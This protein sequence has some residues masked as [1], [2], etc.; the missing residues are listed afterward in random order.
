MIAHLQDGRYRWVKYPRST[1]DKLLTFVPGP[2]NVSIESNDD[3]SLS[4]SFFGTSAE[5]RFVPVEP[6]VFKQI[7]GGL[8]SIGGLQ[9]DLGDT[10]VFREDEDGRITYGLVPLQNSAFEKLAWYE[11]P[12]AMLGSFNGLAS[13][14]VPIL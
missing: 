10:L 11:G 5:W 14:P 4:M 13:I 8:Q 6:L 7:S 3:G 12:E 2:Y 9:I 1:L